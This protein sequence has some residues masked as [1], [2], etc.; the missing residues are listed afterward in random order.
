MLNLQVIEELVNAT[1]TIHRNNNEEI[2]R[3]CLLILCN[4]LD[5]NDNYIEPVLKS[6][7]LSEI[8]INFDS[9]STRLIYLTIR[10]AGK[11]STFSDEYIQRLLD[12][13]ILSKLTTVINHQLG[14][15][16][17]EVYFCLS[18]I[19]AGSDYQRKELINNFIFMR[20][21]NGMVDTDYDIRKEAGYLFYNISRKAKDQEFTEIINFGIMKKICDAI[22]REESSE[23]SLLL[24]HILDK[25]I[26]IAKQT[27][28]E[29]LEIR[30]I[31]ALE[32][33]LI[34]D[35]T[36]ENAQ[37]ILNKYFSRDI[38]SQIPEKFLFS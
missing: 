14:K 19:A 25:L 33:L 1:K 37:E 7:I 9:K 21:M 6:G 22:E 20:S 12:L 29:E 17:K 2:K 34:N 18:N 30:Y 13:S 35:K 26:P 4:L 36:A 16:R 31:S 5:S 11:I 23:I 24:I 32:H 38:S 8:F 28:N 10:V 3:N 27:I 15:I